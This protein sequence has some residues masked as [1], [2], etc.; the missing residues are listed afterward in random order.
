M[1]A[2]ESQKQKKVIDEA[3]TEHKT[4][5]FASLMDICHLKNSEMEPKIQKYKGGVVLRGDI[6]TDD[7]GS[8]AVF[9]EQGSSASQW[10]LQK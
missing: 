8:Y 10:R 6:V 9:K 1:A 5:H 2:D 7:S 3:R 4:V